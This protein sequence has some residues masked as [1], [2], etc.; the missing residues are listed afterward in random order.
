MKRIRT[1]FGGVVATVLAVATSGCGA[2]QFGA[3]ADN[4]VL[5][6]AAEP[7][8]LDPSGSAN[9]NGSRWFVDLAY[10]SLITIDA[11]GELSPALA[12]SWEFE[13]DENTTLRVK[14]REGLEFSNGEP[15]D[16]DAVVASFEYFKEEGSGPTVGSFAAIEVTSDG[17]HEVIFTSANP[18][19]LLPVLLTPRYMGGAIIAPEGLE[20]PSQLSTQT[21]GAGPYQLDIE[22]TIKGDQYV[23]VPNE[24]YHDEDQQAFDQIEIQIISNITSQVQAL[25]TEQID[26]MLADP[27]AVTEAQGEEHISEVSGPG[28]W[29]GF[30]LLDREGVTTPELADK[31]VR[32][33]LNY[34]L[35]REA[36]ATAA[37]GDYG[38]AESQPVSP[39][40]A[41]H[42][43]DES[44]KHY[45]EY[46]PDKAMKLLEEAGVE[47]GF[48]MEVP[49][50]SHI[51]GTTTMVEAAISQ[52]EEIGVDVS[53]VPTNSTGD[54]SQLYRS[55]DYPLTQQNSGGR[56]MLSNLESHFLA[57]STMNP[58]EVEVPEITD[59]FHELSMIDYADSGP[60]S[61]EVSKL[62]VEEA[63]AVPIVLAEEIVLYN[64]EKLENIQFLGKGSDISFVYDW[65]PVAE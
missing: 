17:S 34:A 51:V 49:Y 26:A 31:R 55:G 40:D 64:N 48:S 33:A 2:T 9:G 20:D 12:E 50:K 5:A 13:D 6:M 56:P 59:A 62:L 41:S 63:V 52:W 24:N 39:G 22:P 29:N 35:D 28:F 23:F 43:Y 38:T 42:G 65:N 21:F 58:F 3:Q 47:N 10:Q 14:L 8:T 11:E 16:A 44:L 36:I 18:N 60:K 1:V 32:Q 4:L 27:N 46:D 45:Y 15:L 61:A 54:W 7:I 57:H 25:K 30:Y 37:Y 19:P 53:L